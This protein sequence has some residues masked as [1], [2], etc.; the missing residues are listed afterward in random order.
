MLFYISL[1]GTACFFRYLNIL[2]FF[3][4]L[5]EVFKLLSMFLPS[6]NCRPATSCTRLVGVSL[7]RL[8]E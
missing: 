4:L 8:P 1:L 7:H 3:S 5:H 2:T 6:E